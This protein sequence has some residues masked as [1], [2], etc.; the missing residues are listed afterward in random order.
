MV[1]L[2]LT[3][4]LSIGRLLNCIGLKQYAFDTDYAEEKV[5]DG[6]YII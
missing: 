3:P 1:T 6:K 5:D 4:E 2:S